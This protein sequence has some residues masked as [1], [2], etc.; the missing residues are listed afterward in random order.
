MGMQGTGGHERHRTWGAAGTRSARGHKGICGAAGHRGHGDTPGHRRGAVRGHG[1]PCMAWRHAGSSAALCGD[2]MGGRSP[3]GPHRVSSGS[4]SGSRVLGFCSIHRNSIKERP[5]P[6]EW[7]P[8][9]VPRAGGPRRGG[10]TMRAPWRPPQ[11]WAPCSIPGGGPAQIEHAEPTRS[12]Q[13]CAE[14]AGL[15]GEHGV[16]EATWSLQQRA[17]VCRAG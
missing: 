11:C 13:R 2:T 15:G 10:A 4:D 12:T 1:V 3:A 16:C 14:C 9:P 6:A 7:A 17:V 5:A 8:P